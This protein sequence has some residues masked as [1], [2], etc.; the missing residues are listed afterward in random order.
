MLDTALE[1]IATQKLENTQAICNYKTVLKSLRCAKVEIFLT[2]KDNLVQLCK[3]WYNRTLVNI[4]Q[5]L[6]VI[7]PTVKL[8]KPIINTVKSVNVYVFI[9]SSRIGYINIV[10][11]LVDS[12][13]ISSFSSINII[14]I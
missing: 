9:D 7:T 3:L 8:D 13:T 1:F 2:K 10:D 6:V 11:V 5:I 4:K 12:S 14:L